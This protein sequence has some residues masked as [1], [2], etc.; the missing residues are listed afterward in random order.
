MEKYWN[1]GR[2]ILRGNPNNPL[3]HYSNT[4]LIVTKDIYYYLLTTILISNKHC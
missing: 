2:K 4:K 3:F 1:G